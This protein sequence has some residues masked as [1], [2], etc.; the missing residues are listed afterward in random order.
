MNETTAEQTLKEWFFTFGSGHADEHGRHL[1]N[2]YTRVIATTE[3]EARA[4]M[5]VIRG[6]KWC[7]SYA[8]KTA[9]GVSR[10]GLCFLPLDELTPQPKERIDD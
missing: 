1:M 6:D 9:A 5:T 2:Y 7:T 3:A 8:S 10:F 4:A